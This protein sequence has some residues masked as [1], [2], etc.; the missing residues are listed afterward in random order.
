MFKILKEKKMK[1]LMVMV[2]AL[3]MLSTSAYAADWNFYGS[4]RISTFY[5]SSEAINTAGSTSDDQYEQGLQGN[6]RLGA[7]VKVSDELTGGFEYGAG[8]GVANIRKLY[9]EWN[10]G[11]GKLLVGQTYTPLNWFYSD[12]VYGTDNDLLAQGGVYSGREGML[13]LTFGGLKVALLAP[14]TSTDVD[15]A[16]VNADP[17]APAVTDIAV[18]STE[19]K[20]PGIEVSYAMAM[21]NFGVK[22]GAG[23]QSFD[24]KVGTT[25]YSVDSYVIALGGSANFG[26]MYVNAN[27]YGGQNVGNMFAIDVD[28]SND[29]DGGMGAFTQNAAET[30]VIFVDNDALGMLIVAG[31]TLNDMF[32]F[33]AGYG[34]I[35]TEYDIN[36]VAKDKAQSYYLNS[37]ITLAPGVFFVP[38]IGVVDGDEA[39]DNKTDYFGIKWQI[40]F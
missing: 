29:W 13:Q 25:D 14:N 5:T 36:G 16:Y 11:A 39:G 6:A 21:D 26:A 10:F 3:A 23:Y 24:A 33:E 2:A 12:Q 32:N 30:A 17:E 1:K 9:G 34:Y 15:P 31:F 40:N 19:T 22:L 35:E 4:A 20:M 28:G 18:A 37:T 7:T 27:I 8:G 38:E